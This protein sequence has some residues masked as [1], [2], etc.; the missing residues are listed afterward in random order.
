MFEP[1]KTRLRNHWAINLGRYESHSYFRLILARGFPAIARRLGRNRTSV[2]GRAKMP[3]FCVD[4]SAWRSV[5]ER[6]TR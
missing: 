5:L 2:Q 4:N 1:K 6:I 3:M